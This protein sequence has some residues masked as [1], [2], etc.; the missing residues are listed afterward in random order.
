MCVSCHRPHNAE[1]TAGAFILR[2]GTVADGFAAG[3][4]ANTA[5]G[6]ISRQSD[7]DT[8]YANKIYGEYV[9]LCKGCHQG[10]GN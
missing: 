4:A 9:P 1:T 3:N 2:R 8:T 5:D 10:Y 7:V 6:G